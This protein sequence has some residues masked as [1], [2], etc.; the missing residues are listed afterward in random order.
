MDGAGLELKP[1]DQAGTQADEPGDVDPV[2]LT[3]P[4]ERESVRNEIPGGELASADED[5]LDFEDEP[6]DSEEEIWGLVG[7]KEERNFS[8]GRGE[9]AGRGRH[10]MR[11]SWRSEG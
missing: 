4:V 6:E 10:S 2:I 5:E 3:E 8:F 11:P 1:C 9:D 7:V